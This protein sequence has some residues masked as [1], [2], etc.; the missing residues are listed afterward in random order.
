MAKDYSAVDYSA[1][2]IDYLRGHS[3]HIETLVA[4][5]TAPDFAFERA[6][7]VI[8]L[9]HVI[10]HLEEPLALLNSL[11]RFQFRYLIL[12]VPLDD[13]LV[14]RLSALFV[15]DRTQNLA[16]HV[17]FFTGSS[18]QRLLKEGGLEVLDSRG[19][20]PILDIDTI[21]FVCKKNR[22]SRKT[23]FKMLAGR[24]LRL[25]TGPI[26]AYSL[27]AHYAVLSRPPSA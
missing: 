4:D 27:S 26:W 14:G 8:V 20:L 16:G 2:A 21:E 23:Y 5:V 24:Y 1:T 13:L 11:Q 25:L 19:Y 12:E 15:K 17:Q 9:S 22:S 18:F 6:V 7:D 10:E 3:D